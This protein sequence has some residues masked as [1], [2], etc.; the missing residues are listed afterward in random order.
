MKVTIDTKE[1]SFEDIQKIVHLL[2]NIIG[3]KTYS[4]APKKETA[5]TT[6]LM[7]MFSAAESTI[8]PSAKKE[9]LD[10]APDFSSF[11]NL[12]QQKQQEEKKQVPKI[13]FF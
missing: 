6:D 4:N 2:T 13:E 5:D 11:L 10:T 8:E 3:K 7:S 9:V 12:A 1:D